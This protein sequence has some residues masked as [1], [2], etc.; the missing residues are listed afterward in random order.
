MSDGVGK[1][2]LDMTCCM[3]GAF[4][5]DI[6]LTHGGRASRVNQFVLGSES[7]PPSSPA[8]TPEFFSLHGEKARCGL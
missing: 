2:G 5:L 8:L 4:A 7:L 6:P 1:T 3:L